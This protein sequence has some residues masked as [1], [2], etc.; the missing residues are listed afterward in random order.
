MK[1]TKDSNLNR[2][3]K[4]YLDEHTPKHRAEL[5]HLLNPKDGK[6]RPITPLLRDMV[7]DYLLIE[8]KLEKADIGFVFGNKFRPDMIADK[9]AELYHK[10]YFKKLII[11]GG[12]LCENGETEANYTYKLLLKRGVPADAMLRE[13]RAMNTG[14]NV[15]F[16]LPIL[17]KEIGLKNIKSIIAIGK[18]YAARRYLM[19]L[20][21]WIPNKRLMIAPINEFSLP[22]QRWT[23]NER[24]KQVVLREFRKIVPYLDQG[25]LMP[26]D[27]PELVNKAADYK[28]NIKKAPV[29]PAPK[30]LKTTQFK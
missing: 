28:K 20:E 21:R 11:S 9:A 17:Q 1:R 22:K 6:K 10:G 25:F 18:T 16:S 14:Q 8:S 13:N 27:T 24:F 19:T 29:P 5:A 30:K 2:F 15:E 12:V 26:V 7:T 23:D 3:F 4:K